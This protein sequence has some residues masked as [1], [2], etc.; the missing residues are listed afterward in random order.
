MI[1]HHPPSL[2]PPMARNTSSFL[3][4]MCLNHCRSNER[5]FLCNVTRNSNVFI[6][7]FQGEDEQQ[8]I[9]R[10][11]DAPICVFECVNEIRMRWIASC[12]V[13]IKTELVLGKTR[14]PLQLNWIFIEQFLTCI[15]FCMRLYLPTY[16]YL[17]FEME[18]PAIFATIIIFLHESR[19]V[20]N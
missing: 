20:P 1:G 3:F 10:M 15:I 13:Q 8:L 9:C 14:N 12:S 18:H 11:A 5:S 16:V 17:Y 4:R 19:L 2:C 7:S 6:T